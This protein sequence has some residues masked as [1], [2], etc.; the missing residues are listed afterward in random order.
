[1]AKKDPLGRAVRRIMTEVLTALSPDTSI[2]AA[3]HL[4]Q[5]QHMSGAPVV[6][7]AGHLLGVVS[8]GDLADAPRAGVQGRA[9][10]YVVHGGQTLTS[11][12][13]AGVEP[14]PGVVADVM[15]REVRSISPDA[16]LRDAVRLMV[17][18]DIHRVLVVD[19]ERLLGL[20]STMDVLRELVSERPPSDDQGF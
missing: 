19:G 15:R 8:V 9:S 6:D 4:L 20:I 13:I 14:S 3:A 1:M 10:F 7:A 5:E 12:V 17:A 16:P 11:S 2:G 18:H